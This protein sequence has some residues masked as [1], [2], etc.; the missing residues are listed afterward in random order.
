MTIKVKRQNNKRFTVE[1][2]KKAKDINGKKVQV[3]SHV[4]TFN[5]QKAANKINKLKK[6]IQSL[7]DELIEIKSIKEKI[8]AKEGN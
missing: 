6:R 8:D 5:S 2:Y 4:E 1:H 7:Q 3:L